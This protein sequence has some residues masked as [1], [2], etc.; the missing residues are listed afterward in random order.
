MA[1]P[2]YP[3]PPGFD[4]RSVSGRAP[5]HKRALFDGLQSSSH[6]CLGDVDADT[7]S[8]AQQEPQHLLRA[9]EPVKS[10]N[11]GYRRD[12]SGATLRADRKQRKAVRHCAVRAPCVDALKAQGTGELQV[13]GP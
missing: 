3:H 11:V 10:C 12:R 8:K 7:A 9:A 5:P 6:G 13:Q 2:A 1:R 4:A